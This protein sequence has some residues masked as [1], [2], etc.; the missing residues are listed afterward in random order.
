MSNSAEYISN[1]ENY[2]KRKGKSKSTIIAY[3][4]DLKQLEETN[5]KKDLTNFSTEDI[6]KGLERLKNDLDLTNKTISRKL[7][8]IRTFYKYLNHKAVISENPATKIPH[9]KFPLKKQRILKPTEYYALKEVSREDIKL[10]TIIELM[11]QTGI[12]IGELS[13]LKVKDVKIYSSK[14]LFIA[15]FSSNKERE[16]E[17][18]SKALKAIELYLQNYKHANN[19]NA[20]LFS[21]RTGKPIQIRNIRSIIDRVIV[22]AKI[23]NACVNDIRNTFIVH[24][25][26][27][28][29]TLEKIAQFV[30]HK[31]TTTTEKYLNLL[32]KKYNPNGRERI[33]EL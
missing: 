1:F 2:L 15:S 28:G 24:Q 13:R 21:T 10:F 4:K 9:P 33:V 26:E 29:L 25:L 18:N 6:K 32:S 8:S 27:N 5:V 23:K 3:I 14:T 11:L 19:P 7:N 16:I 31:N 22:K 20:P 30:G 17:L 12:R